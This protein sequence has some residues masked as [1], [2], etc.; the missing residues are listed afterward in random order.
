MNIQDYLFFDIETHRVNEWEQL[1]PQLQ[2]AFIHKL[3]DCNS[4][5][6]PA[7]HYNEVAGLHAEFSHAICACFGY[8]NSSGQ[9]IEMH[10]CDYDEPTFLKK[11]A[12][13]FIAFK[14]NG[15]YLAGHNI[16]ACDEPYLCKRY[17]INGMK[18]PKMINH[19]GEK[20]WDAGDLD[21]M[22]MWKFGMWNNIS[23]E[24][25]CASLGIQVKSDEIG[26]GN[27]WTYKLEDIPKDELIHYC[28]E[29]VRATYELAKQII[30]CIE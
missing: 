15:Y 24:V 23:L 1:T 20:P 13:I 3:Y 12:Q 16:L 9:W 7:A 26:G 2:N 30:K 19:F 4:Y 25:A 27:L 14:R 28:T 17:I 11:C 18:I 21:T 10:V 6:T 29:D 8:E 22:Q 5:E